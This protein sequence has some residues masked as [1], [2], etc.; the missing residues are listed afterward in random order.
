MKIPASHIIKAILIATAL[1]LLCNFIWIYE[2]LYIKSWDG[3]NWLNG[4]MNSVFFIIPLTVCSFIFPVRLL[5]K[6]RL[7]NMIIA[8]VGLSVISLISFEIARENLYTIYSRFFGLTYSK[9]ISILIILFDILIPVLIFSF[10]YYFIINRLIFRIYRIT[11]FLFSI[12]ILFSIVFG[13]LT[14]KMYPGFGSGKFFVDSVKMG[15]PIFWLNIS[16]GL[17]S[18]II[19]KLQLKNVIQEK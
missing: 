8:F 10:G 5:R 2:I 11:I 13:L 16:F 9:T 17:I 19:L 7:K 12:S 3:L 15:Y 4:H 14:V 1:G 18:L 6:I